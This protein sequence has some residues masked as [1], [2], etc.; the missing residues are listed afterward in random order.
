MP[1]I[2]KL[3]EFIAGTIKAYGVFGLFFIT[4]LSLALYWALERLK[5]Q[6]RY[7]TDAS[8]K[9][10]EARLKFESEKLIERY[11]KEIQLLFRDEEL[12]KSIIDNTIQEANKIRLDIYKEVYGLFFDV[13]YGLDAAR[14]D[15]SVAKEKHDELYKKVTAVRTKIFINSVQMGRLTDFLLNAQIA[16]WSDIQDSFQTIVQEP[17]RREFKQK[18]LDASKELHD[19]EKWIVT[20]M[21]TT[22]TYAHFE[23]NPEVVEKLKTGRDEMIERILRA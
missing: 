23:L 5:N 4:F 8:L 6:T 21:G 18:V 13:L 2:G 20:E 12:R 3:Q 14:K 15:N 1:E 17:F 19:A 7:E 11:R 10:L 22:K 9:Q 16:L